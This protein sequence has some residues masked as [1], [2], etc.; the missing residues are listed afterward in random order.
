MKELYLFIAEKL[1]NFIYIINVRK[2]LFSVKIDKII[3]H[4]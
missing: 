4:N 1:N 2:N 3:Q